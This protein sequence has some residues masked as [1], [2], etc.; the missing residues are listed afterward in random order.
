[1]VPLTVSLRFRNDSGIERMFGEEKIATLL[2]AIE[3]KLSRHTYIRRAPSFPRDQ[4]GMPRHDPTLSWIFLQRLWT[5]PTPQQG[6]LAGPCAGDGD[7]RAAME[8]GGG[9]KL[10]GA[11]Q[12]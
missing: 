10:L 3:T 12:S 6:V 8:G 4:G 5:I 1:M 9:E 7:G 11:S 2:Q